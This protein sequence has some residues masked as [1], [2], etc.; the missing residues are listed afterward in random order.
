MMTLKSGVE[1]R[2]HSLLVGML[3]VVIL[4]PWGQQ[5][6]RQGTG[7]HHWAVDKNLSEV[8]PDSSFLIV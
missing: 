1:G 8:Y 4:Q 3:L 7:G 6:G 2:D 5:W